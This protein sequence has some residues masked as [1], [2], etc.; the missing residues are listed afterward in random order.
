MT[1][2]G[3]ASEPEFDAYLARLD[4]LMVRGTYGTILDASAAGRTPPMQRQKQ[5]TWLKE[6]AATL[7]Q[8]Q[9]GTAFIITNPII[10]GVLTAIMWIQPMPNPHA[11]VGSRAEALA[12]V[13]K[14]LAA[15]SQ[16]HA[17]QDGA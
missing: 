11:V 1:F 5:A 15:G 12:W 7:K 16:V 6:R 8:N 14:R 4:Q 10:R 2:S 9:V 13:T 17:H 3:V